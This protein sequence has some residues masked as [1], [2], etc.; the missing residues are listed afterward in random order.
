MGQQVAFVGIIDA[1]DVEA[2][3]HRFGESRV[4]LGRVAGMLRSSNPARILPDLARK[5]WNLARWEVESRLREAQDRRTVRALRAD[6]GSAPAEAAERI[7]G[8]VA[9]P[10]L[11]LYEVAHKE[12]RPIGILRSTSVALFKAADDTGIPDD[13]PYRMVYRDYALGWGKRVREDIVILDV[14]GGHS[15]SLQEPHV[16]TLAP[17]FQAALDEALAE[18]GAWRGASSHEDHYEILVEAAE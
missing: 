17:L 8:P 14:P 16:D 12:H 10:F 2:R 15:S 6:G 13:M 5:T 4:R 9:I 11:K 18:H 1:A 7:E 3:K